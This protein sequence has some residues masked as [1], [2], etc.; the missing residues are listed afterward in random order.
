M[1]QFAV[2]P[3]S[4]MASL[5]DGAVRLVGAELDL[6]SF[7]IQLLDFPPGFAGYPEHDHGDDGMEE[8]YVVLDGSAEFEIDGELVPLDST[9]ILRVSPPARR[10]LRP[11]PDG[12]RILA[13]GST[14][15]RPY[16][17]PGTFTVDAP[18]AAH[19]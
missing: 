14:I 6:K 17:R 1:G 10:R 15:G 3:V 9:R 18:P 4:E 19:A 12:V 7:G 11:G 8:V 5:H 16:E 2:R 13:I